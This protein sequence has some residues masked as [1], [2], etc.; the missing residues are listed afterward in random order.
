MIGRY[1]ISLKSGMTKYMVRAQ[2]IVEREKLTGRG[3]LLLVIGAD[4]RIAELK[5]IKS[6]GNESLDKAFLEAVRNAKTLVRVPEGLVGREFAVEI[7]ADFR[8][9]DS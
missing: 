3:E 1:G 9:R 6:T 8:P 7:P 4:G 5:M 2:S